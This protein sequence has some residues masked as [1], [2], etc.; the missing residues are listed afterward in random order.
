VVEGMYEG[1]G[2]NGAPN[3]DVSADGRS[4][5]MIRQNDL[6]SIAQ[7]QLDVVV[8]WTSEL[9]GRVRPSQ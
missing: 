3:Y 6:T 8:N 7:T 5:L 9:G 4:F 2:A 1:L